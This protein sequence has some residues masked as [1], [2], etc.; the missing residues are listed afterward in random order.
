MITK[1]AARVHVE[2][3]S[4]LLEQLKKDSPT[5]DALPL[6]AFTL[7]KLFRQCANDQVIEL[8]EYERLGGM[9]GAI[10]QAVARILPQDL[11][12]ENEHALRL[13]FVKHLAQVNE[14]DE[15]VRRPARWSD[16]PAAAKP[17]LE[18]F[19]RERLLHRKRRQ[20]GEAV[21]HLERDATWQPTRT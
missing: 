5:A 12:K 19:V 8:H 7:E 14:K 20:E 10:S 18:Q 2:V 1:P 6:L 15:F 17:L 11:P 3:A 21:E 13:S 9:T 4:D 16:L